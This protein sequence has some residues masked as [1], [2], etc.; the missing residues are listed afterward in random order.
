MA[1][2]NDRLAQLLALHYGDPNSSPPSANVANEMTPTPPEA[3]S[4][5]VQ[6][7]LLADLYGH[8]YADPRL[9]MDSADSSTRDVL[10]LAN[11][12][13]VAKEREPYE[14]LARL[15]TSWMPV[16]SAAHRAISGSQ[17]PKAIGYHNRLE[18]KQGNGLV[19]PLTK[20]FLSSILAML[21]PGMARG[22]R[23]EDL[24]FADRPASM[25]GR[26]LDKSENAT[27]LLQPHVEDTA[28]ILNYLIEKASRAPKNKTIY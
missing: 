20:P 19:N 10:A 12:R 16:A 3:P 11:A 6:T 25:L 17:L 27:T 8:G 5:P 15:L 7:N 4:S 14:A 18:Q 21:A 9:E 23:G 28:H 1:D 26:A 13:Q 22:L 2:D 24:S